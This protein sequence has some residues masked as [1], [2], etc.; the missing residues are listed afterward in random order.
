MDEETYRKFDPWRTAPI[1]EESRKKITSTHYFDVDRVAL[2][3]PRIGSFER[4]IIRENNGDTVG[5]LA[6]DDNGLIPFVEQYRVPSHRWT[7]EIPAGH[8]LNAHES[9]QDVAARKLQEEAGFTALHL[10]QF[11]RFINTPSFSTQHTALFYATGLKPA[12]RSSIGPE[13]PRSQVRFYSLDEAMQMVT[14]G[15]IVDAKTII[16]VLRLAQGLHQ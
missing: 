5:V 7:L 2:K 8:A 14:N 10:A 11:T 3:S 15:T 16:A 9:L 1:V 4:T 12:D 13:S 6:V